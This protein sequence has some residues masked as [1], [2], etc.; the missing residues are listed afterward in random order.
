MIKLINNKKGM[1]LAF[2]LLFVAILSFLVVPIIDMFTYSQI[3]AV[4][5]KNVLTA[6]NLASEMIEETKATKFSSIIGM[7]DTEWKPVEGVWFKDTESGQTIN[8]PPDYAQYKRNL[9]VVKGEDLP[10]KDKRLKIIIVTVKWEEIGKNRTKVIKRD[11][12]LSTVI[13]QKEAWE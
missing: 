1:S 13:N 5:A 7:S 4:K 3:T 2:V 11:L 9:K 6:L 8:Y 12:K 10:S